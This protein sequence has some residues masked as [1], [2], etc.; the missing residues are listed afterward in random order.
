MCGLFCVYF[1]FLNKT[2]ED[3][4]L[5]WDKGGITTILFSF[6]QLQRKDGIAIKWEVDRFGFI[7]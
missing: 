7:S 5:L 4:T 1:F 2:R 3:V 6:S